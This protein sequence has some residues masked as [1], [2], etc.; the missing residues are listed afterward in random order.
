VARQCLRRGGGGRRVWEPCAKS[1]MASCRA[2]LLCVACTHIH[3]RAHTHTHIRTRAMCEE[4]Y[5]L[6]C[7]SS[8]H[9]I[10]T[11]IHARA[12]HTY[13]HTYLHAYYLHSYT[14]DLVSVKRDLVSVKRDILTRI[15]L[16]L[17]HTYTH[18]YIHTHTHIH[19][20]TDHVPR[21]V[22]GLVGLF[23]LYSRSLLPL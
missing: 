4:A 22:H 19:T 20:Y 12:R 21:P 5:G 8:V 17:I 11:H 14:L 16:A 10:H 2:P 6:P 3:A 23:C 7:S 13:M 9:G 1:R 18:A 15:L